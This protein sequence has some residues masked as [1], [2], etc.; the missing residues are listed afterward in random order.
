MPKP[1]KKNPEQTS[2]A[3][4]RKAAKILASPKSTAAQKSVA[5]SALTQRPNRKGKK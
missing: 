5:G 2:K 3:V 4:G 1:A